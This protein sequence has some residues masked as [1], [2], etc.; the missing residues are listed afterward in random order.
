M[1]T[2]N[3][4]DANVWLALVWGRH[5][6]FERARHWFES[7]PDDQFLYCRFTQL[8]V[9]RLLTTEKLMAHDTQ[10]MS[11]AWELW[12]RLVSDPR[13]DFLVEPDGLDGEF[14]SHSRLG[15]KSP[16]VWADAYLLAFSSLAGTRLVSFD[17]ALS[18]RAVDVL[19]L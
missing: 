18:G 15:S 11:G 5:S 8:T 12:D 7:V 13:I 4:L 10:S 2:S 16:K 9:L 14:R 6:H 19:V 3:F 17:R 1:T